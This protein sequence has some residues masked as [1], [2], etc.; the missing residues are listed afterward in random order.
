MFLSDSARRRVVPEPT[1]NPSAGSPVVY[2]GDRGKR[3]IHVYQPR[4][5]IRDT[6]APS[7]ALIPLAPVPS[8]Q[9]ARLRFVYLNNDARWVPRIPAGVNTIC[10]HSCVY[11]QARGHPR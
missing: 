2:L 10:Q 4:I 6:K 1:D 5:E 9:P 3:Y 11:A 7:F 8:Q